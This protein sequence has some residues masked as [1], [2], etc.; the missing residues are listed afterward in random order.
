MKHKPARS[1]K[2]I[3]EGGETRTPADSRVQTWLERRD[4]REALDRLCVESRCDEERLL[5]DL[6]AVKLAYDVYRRDRPAN[7]IIP[8]F[9]FDDYFGFDRKSLETVLK[10]MRQC[11]KDVE[12][13]S[14]KLGSGR[15]LEIFK[16]KLWPHQREAHDEHLTGRNVAR[17]SG[18]VV[19][20]IPETLFNLADAVEEES[21]QA[22]FS[23]RPI[24]DNAVEALLRYVRE[25]TGR[26][27]YKE[28]ALLLRAVTLSD[29]PTGAS[30][31][32]WARSRPALRP[33]LRK[34]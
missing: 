26:W 7:D 33:L 27:F 20:E 1:P 34:P 3:Q 4:V 5:T 13:L 2:A 15:L 12:T 28:V 8:P 23:E 6:A 9:K 21:R 30:L 19:P 17:L 25:T 10:R 31:R 32:V 22:T 29:K 14:R 11:A 24:Y 16:I 18:F